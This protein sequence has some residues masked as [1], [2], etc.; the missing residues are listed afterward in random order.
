[1]GLTRKILLFTSLLVVALVAVTLLVASAQA[2]RLARSNIER[3]LADARVVWD[4]FQADRF[5]QLKLGVRVLGNDPAFKA[6]V[7]TGDPPTVLDMLQERGHDIAADV[8]VATD[9]RGRVLARSDR[10]TG[11]EDLSRERLV[12]GA[13]QGAEQAA[14]WRQGSALYQAVAVPMQFGT[15]TVGVLVAGYRIDDVFARQVSRLAHG[16]IAVLVEPPGASPRIAATSLVDRERDALQPLV[17]T[18]PADT[19]AIFPVAVPGDTHL[20][21]RLPLRAA[22]GSETGALLVMRSVSAEMEPFRRFR[23]GLAFTGLGLMALALLTASVAARRITGPLRLLVDL[24]ERVRDGRYTGEVKV[25]SHDEIGA[26][27]TAFDRM[28][29][30]IAAREERIRAMALQDPLT[31]L[32]NRAL[33]G[34]RLEQ[35]LAR[36]RR[37][38]EPV[39][40]L[41]VDIERFKDVND[42]LGPAAGDTVLREIGKR[43]ES[44]LRASDTVARFGGDEFAL[45]LADTGVDEARRKVED[46]LAAM[47]VPMQVGD[48]VLHLD[49]RLGVASCPEHGRDANGLLRNSQLALDIAKRSGTE[50]AVYDA[51]L[52]REPH[53]RLFV[54]EELRRAIA[55][56]EL[57]VHYQPQLDLRTGTL[58][59]AEALVRWKHPRRGLLGPAEFVP[60]AEQTGLIRAMTPHVLRLALQQAGTWAREGLDMAVSVNLSAL[61]LLS[62]DLPDVVAR[63]LDECR[64]EASRACLEITE[65]AVMQDPQQALHVVSALRDLG[66][67]VAVDDFGT[68]Y[69]SLAYLKRLPVGELKI[70]H[71]FVTA[72]AEGTDD[73]AIVRA[74]TEMAHSL[75]LEVVAEGTETLEVQSLLKRYGVDVAQGWAIGRPMPADD[76][77][78]LVRS[79]VPAA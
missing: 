33:L 37:Q 15:E 32:P 18:L 19:A 78:R 45:L 34:D 68:G 27:A 61:D 47:R 11:Q 40:V 3:G 49:A 22:T 39:S 76:L 28:R 67:R 72:L 64:V 44:H 62:R 77:A 69:S 60:L 7:Q 55:V 9:D 24:V 36:S 43:L 5:A 2:D 30:G 53:D 73:A 25:D 74:T 65:S 38:G 21:I 31:G 1:V 4:T 12:E 66:V 51:A 20:A 13:L 75:G 71:S 26:L 59:R 56:G 14:V 6:A 79:H 29:E 63:M 35:A 50:V 17:A 23:R 48:R 10:A 42:G 58:A 41:L 16:D 70:D 52:D 8:F 57:V 46:L 54:I